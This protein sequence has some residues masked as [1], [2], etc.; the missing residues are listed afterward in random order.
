MCSSDLWVIA[1]LL[2]LP[3]LLLPVQAVAEE[4]RAPA[5][6]P[7]RWGFRGI[8][9]VWNDPLVPQAVFNSA[10]IA[11][12]AVII[13]VPV[14][15]WAARSLSTPTL[16]ATTRVR[17]LIV[18][19]LPLL[20]PPLAVGQGLRHTFLGAGFGFSLAGI[21]LAHIVYVIPYVL[22]VI[23]PAFTSEL[24][25]REE[26][27]AG[28]GA[29]ALWR[30]RLITFPAVLPNLL[31]AAALGFVVSWSQYGTTLGVGGGI[32]TLPLVLLPF[33]R[34]DPQVS[35]VLSLLFVL[36]AMVAIGTSVRTQR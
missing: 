8:T 5:R 16:P 9:A 14:A 27:A 22:I 33:L 21:V 18:I 36:P 17:I 11:S 30:F 28:L 7:Q 4:W 35:A 12:A 34:A 23:L 31:V 13:S 15:W 19:V 26:A 1:A 2:A 24:H 29:N 6:L 10:I 25:H 3:L 20:L 32:P